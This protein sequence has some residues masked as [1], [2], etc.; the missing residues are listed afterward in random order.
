MC[1]RVRFF[2]CKSLC[3]CVCV[4]VCGCVYENVS[5]GRCKIV[6]VCGLLSAFVRL[7]VSVFIKSSFCRCACLCVSVFMSVCACNYLCVC[8]RVSVCLCAWRLVFL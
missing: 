5:V 8:K 7:C 3:V 2:V 1:V 6:R 4:C